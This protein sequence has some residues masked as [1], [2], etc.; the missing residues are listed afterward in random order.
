VGSDE[1]VPE[2]CHLRVQCPH[3]GQQ[4]NRKLFE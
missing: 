3:L 2:R 4:K 1:I